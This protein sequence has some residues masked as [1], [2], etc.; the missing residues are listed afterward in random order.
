MVGRTRDADIDRRLMDATVRALAR[1]GYAGLSLRQIA[2]ESGSTR[3]AIAR[4]YPARADLVLAAVAARMAAPDFRRAADTGSLRGDLLAHAEELRGRFD[5]DGVRVV[6]ALTC[7]EAAE[8]GV[9]TQAR[10]IMTAG[11]ATVFATII[12]RALRRGELQPERLGDQV[13]SRATELLPAL[14]H[15]RASVDQ[16]AATDADL[17]YF[18]DRVVLPALGQPMPAPLSHTT[19]RNHP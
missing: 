6:A 13:V 17:H 18:V 5:G 1:S 7:A 14:I 12:D 9:A 3:A 11:E 10:R 8:D 16:R 2:A 19:E 15:H 4:R